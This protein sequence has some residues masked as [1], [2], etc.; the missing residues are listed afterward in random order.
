MALRVTASAQNTWTDWA[1]AHGGDFTVAIK[2]SSLSG[3]VT[4]Q[5]K[6]RDDDDADAFTVKT[7]ADGAMDVGQMERGE[8]GDG[9]WLVR[10]G[11]ATGD[12]TS[13]SA[14]IEISG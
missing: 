11:I 12:F 2:P 3:T 10:A 5:A 6:R 1:E 14:V 8:V 13:G 4:V 9:N 7:Y